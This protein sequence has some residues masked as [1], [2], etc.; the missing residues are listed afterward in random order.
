VRLE[1]A[2]L[3]AM[4]G[5]GWLCTDAEGTAVLSMLGVLTTVLLLLPPHGALDP[6][7]RAHLTPS[8]AAVPRRELS[9]AERSL[10]AVSFGSTMLQEQTVWV[11]IE[12]IS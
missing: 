8:P 4:H 11:T 6:S 10:A 12:V 2:D 3:F 1:L 9:M 5:A 7:G